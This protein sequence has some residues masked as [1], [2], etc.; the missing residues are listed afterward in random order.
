[1]S[2]KKNLIEASLN[3]DLSAEDIELLTV[4]GQAMEAINQ[5]EISDKISKEFYRPGYEQFM[6]SKKEEIRGWIA[7]E[8]PIPADNEQVKIDRSKTLIKSL[9][10]VLLGTLIIATTIYMVRNYEKD[11][12]ITKEEI[13]QYALLSYESTGAIHSNRGAKQATNQLGANYALLLEGNC[14]ELTIN[15][16]FNEQE[17]WSQLYCAFLNNDSEMIDFYKSQI[18]EEKYSNYLKL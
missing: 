8:A 18:I 7:N 17:L 16:K 2:T 6:T 4:D 13:L 15:G 12:E 10:F 1:M 9:L 3:Y 14:G 5:A 11:Q